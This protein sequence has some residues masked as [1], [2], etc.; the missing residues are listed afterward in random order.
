MTDDRAILHTLWAKEAI[1]DLVLR[2]CRAIDRKDYN[3][4]AALYHADATDDH[5]AMFNGAASEFI[6]WL[7]SMLETMVATVHSVTNHL[8]EVSGD[9]AVGEVYCLAY[10]RYQGEAGMEELLIG[11]RYLDRYECRRGQ[12][13]F[14]HRKIVADWNELRPSTTDFSAPMFAGAA[15][16]GDRENDPSAAWFA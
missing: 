6:A 16:G 1:R 5:G 2:Y 8:I 11:G 10:H 3:A 7:P 12:W 14:S 9:S 4:L 13:R 15:V